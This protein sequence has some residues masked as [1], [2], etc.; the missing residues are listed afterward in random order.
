MDTLE[1][2]ER[3]SLKPHQKPQLITTFVVPHFLYTLVLVMVPMTTVRRMDQDLTRMVKNIFH[4]PQCTANGLLYC[5]RK[6][7]GLGIPRIET[8]YTTTALKMGLKFQLIQT[9]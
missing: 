8:T 3:S 2:V 7:G 1:R 6:N 4:L 9:P 5:G